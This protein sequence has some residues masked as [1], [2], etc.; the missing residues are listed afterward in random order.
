MP[1]DIWEAAEAENWKFHTIFNK[2]KEL[3]G[4]NRNH[5]IKSCFCALSPI[6]SDFDN[7]K[8]TTME[9]LETRMNKA[10]NTLIEALNNLKNR[11]I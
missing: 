1:K 6:A 5:F 7:G 11:C 4:H 8:I 3:S 10:K 9:E 2:G